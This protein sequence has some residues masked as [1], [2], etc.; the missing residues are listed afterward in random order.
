MS[1]LQR[2]RRTVLILR[3]CLTAAL[4]FVMGR[5][6]STSMQMATRKLPFEPP[7]NEKNHHPDAPADDKSQLHWKVTSSLTKQVQDQQE[8]Q[9][10][11]S[12]LQNPISCANSRFLVRTAEIPHK[13]GFASDFQ[14]MARLLQSAVSTR[15]ILF[16]SKDWTS[17]YA[18]PGCKGWDCLFESPTNCTSLS[19][20][21]RPSDKKDSNNSMIQDQEGTTEATTYDPMESLTYGILPRKKRRQFQSKI[22]SWFDPVVYG[23]QP[24]LNA[25]ISFPLK[26]SAIKMDVIPH[27]ERAYGRFWIRA[28]MS[29]YLWKLS[30]SF[31]DTLQVDLLYNTFLKDRPY[32]GMHVRYTDNIPDFAKSFAR[33]ATETRKLENFMKIA[34]AIRHKWPSLQTIYLATDHSKMVSWAKEQYPSW[35]WICQ[36]QVQRHTTQRRVWFTSGRAT[37]GSGIATDLELLR[38]ADILIGSFQS[39]VYRLAAQLNTAYH[40]ANYSVLESHHRHFTVDVEWFE[41]P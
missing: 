30:S 36:P 38:R 22:S 19:S 21:V 25:P 6:L 1:K 27:W 10:M 15:R 2:R 3:L 13:D 8:F 11:I 41:D 32:I 26:H 16:V 31:R 17:A 20:S 9:N 29:H 5:L 18:P 23:P 35:T 33:N 28:Q 39:N 12:R 14:Y 37:A 24:I 7:E 34:N 4:S 40:A